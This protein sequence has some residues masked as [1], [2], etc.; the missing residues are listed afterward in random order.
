MNQALQGKNTVHLTDLANIKLDEL[1]GNKV[2]SS[3]L[4]TIRIKLKN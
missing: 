3:I 4:N 1:T 2:Y